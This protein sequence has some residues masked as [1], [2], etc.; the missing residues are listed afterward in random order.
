MKVN[1][2]K[3]AIIECENQNEI[4]TLQLAL[5]AAITHGSFTDKETKIISDLERFLLK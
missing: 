2:R 3:T 5:Q 1:V 4:D